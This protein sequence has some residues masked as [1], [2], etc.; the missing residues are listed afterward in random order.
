MLIGN[1]R[2]QCHF[3]LLPIVLSI[4]H[5]RQD[6][7]VF[8]SSVMD[9]FQIQHHKQLCIKQKFLERRNDKQFMNVGLKLCGMT[10][11]FFVTFPVK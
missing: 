11:F 6:K 5:E 3:I 9:V 10:A 2:T 7:A 4:H 8:F 1:N